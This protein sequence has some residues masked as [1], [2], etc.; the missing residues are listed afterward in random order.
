MF[1]L[2]LYNIMSVIFTYFKLHTMS[3]TRDFS[4]DATVKL[5][6]RIAWLIGRCK[7]VLLSPVTLK[8]RSDG[9][10]STVQTTFQQF[11]PFR[12]NI[13]INVSPSI[14]F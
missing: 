4:K 8:T 11:D 5:G 1:D 2:K 3:K 6:W 13:E 12:L 7:N 14:E 9:V 10:I